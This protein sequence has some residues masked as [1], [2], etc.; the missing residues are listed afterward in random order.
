MMTFFAPASRWA[1]AFAASEKSPVLSTTMSTPSSSQ[2]IWA[3]S[4]KAKLLIGRPLT[5]SRSFPSTTVP[6]KRP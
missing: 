1:R 5:M 3:G 6:W 2:G 4:R